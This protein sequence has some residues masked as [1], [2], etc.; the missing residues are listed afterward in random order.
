M[1]AHQ[2]KTGI[3]IQIAKCPLNKVLPQESAEMGTKLYLFI[4]SHRMWYWKLFNAW[5]QFVFI[6]CDWETE[7]QE[8]LQTF[9]KIL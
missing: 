6:A 3:G 4:S 7:Y 1:A 9:L 2:E 8:A 5:K